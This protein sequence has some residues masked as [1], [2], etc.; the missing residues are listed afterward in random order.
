MAI[1]PA[2]QIRSAIYHVFETREQG[3]DEA[4]D[5]RVK[6]LAID[7]LLNPNEDIAGRVAQFVREL[8]IDNPL[9]QK[10]LENEFYQRVNSK[11]RDFQQRVLRG[12]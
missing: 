1:N 8:G 7:G 5:N 4:I 9:Q 10:S 2:S 6:L 3:V 12:R 11:K